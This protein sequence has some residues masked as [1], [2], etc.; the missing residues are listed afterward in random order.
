M[1]IDLSMQMTLLIR[2]AL[3]ASALMSTTHAATIYSE[4][5]VGDLSNTGLSPTMVTLTSGSNQLFGATGREAEGIDRDYF[6][7]TVPAGLR[8]TS[9]FLLPNTAIAGDGGFIGLQAGPQVTVPPSA[10]S[11]AGLLGWTHYSADQIGTNML[12][13]LSVPSAGATGF[14]PPLGSGTYSV[15]VQEIA[16]GSFA[17][18]L[19]LVVDPAPVPEPGTYMLALTGLAAIAMVRHRRS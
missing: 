1:L 13:D 19:D 15:W 3:I 11:A 4:A 2:T 9:I 12:D 7:F 5:A 16:T 8:L 10:A 17:Y 6:S 18:G 14:V